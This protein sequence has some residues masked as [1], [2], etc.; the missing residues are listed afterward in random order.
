MLVSEEHIREIGKD[1]GVLG[2]FVAVYCRHH[3]GEAERAPF[4]MKGMDLSTTSLGKRKV[5]DECARLLSHAVTKRA[6]C[7]LDPKP[8]CRL[9]TEHCYAPHYRERIREVMKFSGRHLILRGQLHLLFHFLKRAPK[10]PPE[11]VDRIC[12]KQ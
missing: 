11:R 5:C 3:H 10:K 6:L 1:L 12:R 2:K 4:A 7:P 9:C 8:A